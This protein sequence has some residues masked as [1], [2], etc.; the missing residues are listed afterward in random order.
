MLQT[1]WFGSVYNYAC[2]STSIAFTFKYNTKFF[3]ATF[4]NVV[5]PYSTHNYHYSLNL[6][7]RTLSVS[8]LPGNK[9]KTSASI[10]SDDPIFPKMFCFASCQMSYTFGNILFN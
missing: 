2:M 8:Q 6:R 1:S 3:A 5:I 4:R 9:A 10:I 7:I